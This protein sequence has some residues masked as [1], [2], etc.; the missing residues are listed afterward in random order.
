MLD[1]PNTGNHSR[2]TANTM[3]RICPDQNTGIENQV[4]VMTMTDLSS[5]VPFLYAAMV[6]SA[7]PRTAEM[8]NMLPNRSTVAGTRDAIMSNTGRPKTYDRPSC[9]DSTLSR[10]VWNRTSRGASSPSRSRM[11]SASSGL[12]ASPMM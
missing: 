9:P 8:V 10:Y 4:M 3:S 5:R 1:I 6:P 12:L 11:R 7:M 2:C